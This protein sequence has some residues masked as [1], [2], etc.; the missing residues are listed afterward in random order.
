MHDL[1]SRQ[2]FNIK[3]CTSGIYDN[4][5]RFMKQFMSHKALMTT[6]NLVK[7]LRNN[8]EY[9]QRIFKK[10]IKLGILTTHPSQQL[11]VQSKQ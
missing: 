4:H 7:L 10:K 1:L 6:T 3:H 2:D 11:H 8:L 5:K 9:V